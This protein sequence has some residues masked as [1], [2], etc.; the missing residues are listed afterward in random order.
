MT[1][2][3]CTNGDEQLCKGYHTRYMDK[4]TLSNIFLNE[5]KENTN[6]DKYKGSNIQELRDD[7]L[8]N[9]I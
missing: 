4:V 5:R 8:Q 2:K 9:E 1:R 3:G 6:A 7:M